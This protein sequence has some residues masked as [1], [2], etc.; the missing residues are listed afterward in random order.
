MRFPYE[1]MDRIAFGMALSCTSLNEITLLAVGK[2]D[3]HRLVTLFYPNYP[4]FETSC[5]STCDVSQIDNVPVNAFVSS[6]IVGLRSKSAKPALLLFQTNDE[7]VC[8]TVV[9]RSSILRPDLTVLRC[10]RVPSLLGRNLV[11]LL[12]VSDRLK[13]FG[14]CYTF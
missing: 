1:A 11:N 12:Q 10:L 4:S 14:L 3:W 2:G 8:Y 6:F 5:Q 7:Q 9:W 13:L